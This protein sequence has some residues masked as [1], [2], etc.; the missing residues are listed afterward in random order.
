MTSEYLQFFDIM[1]MNFKN[2]KCRNPERVRQFCI[3]CFRAAGKDYTTFA[4]MRR[5]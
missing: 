4:G 1:A 2:S 3:R 5:F